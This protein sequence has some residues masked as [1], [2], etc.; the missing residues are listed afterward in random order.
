VV[1]A[2]TGTTP[3]R[4]AVRSTR[5]R[6]GSGGAADGGRPPRRAPAPAVLD[7]FALVVPELGHDL[8]SPGET[9]T[10]VPSPGSRSTRSFHHRATPG[11]TRFR[12]S[13]HLRTLPF[14]HRSGSAEDR[15][16]TRL[17]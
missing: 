8:A 15:K 10:V 14:P 6:R 4:A 9:S 5:C 1:R 16:S 13:Q 11:A 3:F 2:V 7:G 17:N 12:S